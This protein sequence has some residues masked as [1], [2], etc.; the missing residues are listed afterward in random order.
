DWYLASK[1]QSD[2]D[3]S[4]GDDTPSDGGDDGGDVTPPDDGG[5][6]GNVT[7]PD[8]G[9]DVTPPDDGGDVAP[10]YRADIGA[11][12]GNQW[13]AR[14]LQ[15]QTLYDR[16]G[17]QYRNADGSVWARFK[18]GKAESEAVSGNID[19]DSNYSQFQLG[20]DILAWGNGQQ[21]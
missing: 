13:M 15:M 16:E 6:G 4:G 5:D 19:M 21:S 1:A 9:G 11:Y 18:A 14:N 17:S 20:G 7:P 8:D 12:M 10:Q 3:D 2:D